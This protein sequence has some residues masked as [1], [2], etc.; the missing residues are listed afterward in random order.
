MLSIEPLK[1]HFNMN[2]WG[3]NVYC[4]NNSTYSLILNIYFNE[5]TVLN[6]INQKFRGEHVDEYLNLNNLRGGIYI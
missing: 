1:V 6:F 5:Y 2:N 4:I 3:F